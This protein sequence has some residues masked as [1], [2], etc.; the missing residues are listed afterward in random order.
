MFSYIFKYFLNYSKYIV[1]WAFIVLNTFAFVYD[2]YLSSAHFL[3]MILL[4]KNLFIVKFYSYTNLFKV[5]LEII[6]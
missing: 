5:N 6:Q 3:Q 4:N 1:R 2:F